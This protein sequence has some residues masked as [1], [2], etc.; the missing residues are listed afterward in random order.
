M[1]VAVL[2]K[3]IL[4]SLAQNILP[5]VVSINLGSILVEKIRV[6][7]IS[8]GGVI[9]SC[10]FID[11][12]SLEERKKSIDEEKL[13]ILLPLVEKLKDYTAPENLKAVYRN[14]SSIKIKRNIILLLGGI[15]GNYSPE[16][17][18]IIY[19]LET[20]LAHEFLH[21][22]SSYYD[23]ENKIIYSGFKQ[24]K[25]DAVI[26]RGLNEGYTELLAF[27]IYDKNKAGAYKSEVKLAKLLE[28]FFDDPKDMEKFYFNHDLPGFVHYLE[29]FA[30]RAEV[31]KLLI[32]ID[33]INISIKGTGNPLVAYNT[34]K[35]QV[36]LYNWFATKNKDPEKLQQ[37]REII[38]ENKLVSMIINK[39]KTRLYKENPYDKKEPSHGSEEPKIKL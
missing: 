11:D 35:T 10:P 30:P 37:F 31:I 17:N 25:Q 26:G 24:Q 22:A 29:Q 5:L 21:L 32:D 19:S 9:K 13:K 20:L 27:K 6:N 8:K 7:K 18:R 39:Q 4:N 14:L 12:L 16:N 23:H 28:F 1:D 2:V 15:G 36:A 34:V 33:S 3:E 38:G